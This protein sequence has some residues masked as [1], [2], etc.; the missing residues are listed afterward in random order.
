LSELRMVDK[1]TNLVNTREGGAIGPGGRGERKREGRVK[2]TRESM[3]GREDKG[4]GARA[5][6]GVTNTTLDVT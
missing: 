6:A 5:R 1:G 2:R 3:A 4:D